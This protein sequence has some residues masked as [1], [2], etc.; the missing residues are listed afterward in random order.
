MHYLVKGLLF[1]DWLMCILI[2]GLL[3]A[4]LFVTIVGAV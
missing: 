2:G 1:I 3:V 4:S